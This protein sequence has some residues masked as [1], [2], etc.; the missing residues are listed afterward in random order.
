MR[1]LKRLLVWVLEVLAEA[2]LLGT[3][4]G[5]LL[6][7]NFFNLISGVWALALAVAAVL[8]L[9]GYY[10]TRALFGVVWRSQ[11]PWLYPAIAAALFVTHMHIAIV[12]SKR[13]LTPFAQAT[14]F[15]CLVGG[16][17]IVFAGAFA[18]NWALRKWTRTGSSGPEPQ[19]SGIVPGSAEG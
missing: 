18:G 10:L 4:L 13:D 11:I 9:H 8:V 17:C 19:H 5:A 3:L 15:P 14:E 6:F 16:A 7:P 12:R 1:T 2:F